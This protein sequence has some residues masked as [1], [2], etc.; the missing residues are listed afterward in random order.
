MPKAFSTSQ[1]T[2]YAGSQ[3]EEEFHKLVLQIW[4]S[5]V[6][7]EE[8]NTAVICPL[9]KKGDVLDCQNYRGISLLNTAYKIFANVLFGKL[10]PF[11]EPRLGEYQC[12]FRPGRST[13]DQIFSL[14]QIL[15][16]T[17]E[18]N[19][20]TSALA[21]ESAYLALEASSLEAGLQVNADKTKFLRVSRD[22][23]T[24]VL[25][26]KDEN[27]LLV[28]ERKI[29]RRIFGAVRENEIWRTRYNHELIN[30]IDR[31]I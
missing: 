14:R 20:D 29:L 26:K 8:W 24:W 19:A 12:G 22:L 1:P 17:L 16:K 6:M 28:F 25:S 21:V 30:A 23:Q 5:E 31:A 18:F 15:E 7:P 2:K 13:I 3:F 27:R 10:K 4:N 9:H 11:V